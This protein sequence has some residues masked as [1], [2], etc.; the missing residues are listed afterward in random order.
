MRVSTC[1]VVCVCLIVASI[2]LFPG[3]ASAQTP[4][5]PQ[6]ERRR[7]QAELARIDNALVDLDGNEARLNK[8]RR[9]LSGLPTDK[10][11]VIIKF[12]DPIGYVPI[13]AS[14]V[15]DL[16]AAIAMGSLLSEENTDDPDSLLE[17]AREALFSLSEYSKAYVQSDLKTINTELNAIDRERARLIKERDRLRIV[18]AQP[19]RPSAPPLPPPTPEIHDLWGTW[20]PAHGGPDVAVITGDRSAY[21]VTGTNGKY[22]NE[23][24]IT[25]DGTKYEGDLYDQPG[26]CCGRE[27]H[28]WVEVIDKDT[29][30]A[31]SIWW[32]TGQST[33]ERPEITNGWSTWKRQT[34]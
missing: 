9:F 34:K 22:K 12:R 5:P 2:P 1:S 16:I 23:G 14:K 28:V 7:V 27:G 3:G 25:G 21:T 19:I 32:K 18:L 13:P 11:A 26:W 24:T 8:R 10:D 4:Q 20:K 15:E 33:R 31:R 17:K 29:Y 6:S 30:R